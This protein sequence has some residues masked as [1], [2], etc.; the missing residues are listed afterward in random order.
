MKITCRVV[1]SE[2]LTREFEV[3]CGLGNQFISWLAQTACL[4][5]GQ[6]HYPKGIYVPNLLKREDNEA[7]H[8]R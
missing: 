8:P 4:K 1:E 3:D 7:P 6:V 5:F 2:F